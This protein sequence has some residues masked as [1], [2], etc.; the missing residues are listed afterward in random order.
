MSCQALLSENLVEG[1][2]PSLAEKGVHSEN[3]LNIINNKNSIKL[4]LKI[5][6]RGKEI[7]YHFQVES[8]PHER[9]DL[10][11]TASMNIY[12]TKKKKKKSIPQSIVMK[13]FFLKKNN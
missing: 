5:R 9:I 6:V 13:T 3:E 4:Y 7:S 8:K 12:Q 1:S 11:I 2:T 10:L